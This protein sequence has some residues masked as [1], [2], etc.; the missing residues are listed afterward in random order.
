MWIMPNQ[1]MVVVRVEEVE[2]EMMRSS[3]MVVV[4]VEEVETEMMSKS[5]PKP[6]HEELCRQ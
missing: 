1:L 4:R 5:N 3:L 2:T 6:P